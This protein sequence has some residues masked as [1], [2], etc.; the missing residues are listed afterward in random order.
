MDNREWQRLDR[1]MLLVH[2][3]RELIR[4]LPVLLGLLLAGSRSGGN[5]WWWNVLGIGVPIALGMAR[6]LTTSFR[7]FEGRVELR[8]GLLNKHV[9]STPIDRV[10]TVDV[11]ASLIHRVLGL[12]TVRIGTGT[13]SK[14][15]DDVLAL[16]GV[17]VHAAD[18]LRS[19]LLH[20]SVSPEVRETAQAPDNA[21]AGRPLR[22]EVALVR[23]FHHR[24]AG[25]RRGRARRREPAPRRARPLG[26]PAAGRGR[27]EA[28]RWSLLLVVPLLAVGAIV[29]ASVMAV[30]GYL[31]TNFGFTVTYTRSDHAW[32]L[33]RGLFT[34]RETSMDANRLRGVSLGEPLGL[35]LA[36]GARLSAIVTGLN[37]EE[38]G[39][40]TLVPPAPRPV[41]LRVA[42]AMLGT[43]EPL[44]TPLLDHGPAATR[45]RYTRALTV[46][47]LL[48]VAL[49]AA[50][51]LADLPAP[52]LAIAPV[53]LVA[54]AGLGY[55]R[56]RG[57]GHALL[58]AH[59]VARS[60]SLARRRVV[61][62]SPGDHRLDDLLH[63]VPAPRRPDRR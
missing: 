58:P 37:R 55:D 61:L 54:G 11:S 20:R 50:V 23:A 15:G 12:T 63:L 60:G 52:L 56:S 13:S 14:A 42:T 48:S 9:L 36:A 3:I 27:R 35:R 30:L 16:D 17:R 29:V 39:S 44:T 10:R 18:A 2:P 7:I 1:L 49:V 45:R 51:V 26:P 19:D 22:A 24:R 43:D 8:H 4:F 59:L 57:L 53:L 25:H 38:Q 31:V 46:P 34:T 28:G 62:D 5:E 47:V 6:Y 33:R 40:S 32:H 41:S 21:A